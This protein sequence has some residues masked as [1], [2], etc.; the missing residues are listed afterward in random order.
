MYLQSVIVIGDINSTF[1]YEWASPMNKRNFVFITIDCGIEIQSWQKWKT[2]ATQTMVN[3]ECTFV[4]LGSIRMV[5]LCDVW[6]R[7]L[8]AM[9][10]AYIIW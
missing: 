3:Y 2:K 7:Q 6:C 5:C 1:V 9:V 4:K 10:Y 8:Q